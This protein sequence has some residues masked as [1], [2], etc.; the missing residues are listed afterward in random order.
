MLSS[1]SLMYSFIS[2]L[3]LGL[4]GVLT[5]SVG[6]IRDQVEGNPGISITIF[7]LEDI[8]D[9]TSH[10]QILVRTRAPQPQCGD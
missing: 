4:S 6:L 2:K 8:Y 7:T 5:F 10:T 1:D 3:G 9:Y